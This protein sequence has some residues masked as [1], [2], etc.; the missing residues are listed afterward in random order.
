MRKF[1][2]FRKFDGILMNR[3]YQG[4]ENQKFQDHLKVY[5]KKIHNY[6]EDE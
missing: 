5:Y 6:R 3:K 2:Y 1:K 4:N